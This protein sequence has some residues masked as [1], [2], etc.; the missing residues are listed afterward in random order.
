MSR[1]GTKT[2][3]ATALLIFLS[4][5]VSSRATALDKEVCDVAADSALGVEDYATAVT[6]H[7]KLLSSHPNVALAHYHLGFAYGMLGREADEIS[8]YHAAVN[9]RLQKWDLFLN[10]GLAYL[11]QHELAS[12]TA[13][14]ETAASLG[15]E[16][17][18]THFNLAV[19]YERQN[20]LP[21]ALREITVS[22][23]LAPDDLDAANTNAIICAELDDLACAHDIWTSLIQRAPDYAPARS[24]VVI[25]RRRT[26]LIVQSRQHRG[27]PYSQR[28]TAGHQ[29]Y[30][31]R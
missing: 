12:A 4:G 29:L 6:L 16:H 28:D 11:G 10:L 5:A 19:V 25:L 14:L 26:T 1:A 2:I 9:L 15:P 22:R 20:R 24:N 3:A 31:V 7:R 17:P 21:D 30:D 18:E 8:E 23:G 13:A 27:L